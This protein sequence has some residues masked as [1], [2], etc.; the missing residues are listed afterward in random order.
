MPDQTLPP[1]ARKP[2]PRTEAQRAASRANG[3]RSRGP[4]TTA[5]KAIA[6]RNATRHG[7]CCTAAD[8]EGRHAL[9]AGTLVLTSES[10]PKFEALLA[11]YLHEYQP[12]GQTETDLVEELAAAK[13][14]QRRERAAAHD[15][16]RNSAILDLA[17]ERMAGDVELE[18]GKVSDS[19]RTALAFLAETD[20]S[21][22][23]QFLSRYAARHT[24]DWHRALDKLREIQRE[25]RS[26]EPVSEPEEVDLPNEP[27]TVST[28]SEIN[29]LPEPSEAVDTPDPEPASLPLHE[30]MLCDA[31][32]HPDGAEPRP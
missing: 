13:W 21:A 20:R 6:S 17:M 8:F 3:A 24:R 18:F 26:A 29:E 1:G 31:P 4:A 28:G 10:R 25:R 22:A 27:G 5:G 11:G 23:L 16:A 9:A 14:L 7:C 30:E 32:H 15:K 12:A 19:E 2:A